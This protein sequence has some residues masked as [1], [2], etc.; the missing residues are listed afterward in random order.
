MPVNSHNDPNL[1]MHWPTEMENVAGWVLF[2]VKVLRMSCGFI[3][4]NYNYGIK[5]CLSVVRKTWI[6]KMPWLIGI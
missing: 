2:I 1:T 3:L 4:L 6:L 5:K